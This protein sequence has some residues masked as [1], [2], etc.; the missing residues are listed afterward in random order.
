[1]K[2]AHMPLELLEAI[3]RLLME[4]PA[5]HSRPLL[6]ALDAQTKVLDDEPAPMQGEI[7]NG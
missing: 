1:M 6:D 7:K 5:K 4:L 3:V 2:T